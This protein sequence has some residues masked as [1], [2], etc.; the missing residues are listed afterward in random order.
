[1]ATSIDLR[2]QT[3]EEL[4]IVSLDP[5]Y[6][7]PKLGPSTGPPASQLIPTKAESAVIP[8]APSTSQVFPHLT[9]YRL[10]DF[11]DPDLS[12]NVNHGVSFRGLQIT[13][14]AIWAAY[15]PK[16]IQ[17]AVERRKADLRQ[18]SAGEM[19]EDTAW[20][21]SWDIGGMS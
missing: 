1:M 16:L 18:D 17:R 13:E 10:T 21:D 11:C 15:H 8:S 5:T 14:T 3:S 2:F 12:W 20:N 6:H 7:F 9:T 19:G 4:Y